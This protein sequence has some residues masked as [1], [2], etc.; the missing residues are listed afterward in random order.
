MRHADG[1]LVLDHGDIV[2]RGTFDELLARRGFFHSL[3][4][5]QFRRDESAEAPPAGG[6]GRGQTLTPAR[7]AP[8]GFRNARQVEGVGRGRLA[9][10]SRQG[11]VT[12]GSAFH[13]AWGRPRQPIESHLRPTKW[14]MARDLTYR[15]SR[16][17]VRLY[18]RAMLQLDVVWKCPPPEG[19]LILAANHPSCTDPFL[20]PLMFH[21]P[22]RLLITQ[23]AFQVPGFGSFLRHLG[24]VP[25]VPR[26]GLPALDAA[27]Q[28]LESGGS[29][30]LFPEGRL[31][32]RRGGFR[33]PRTGAARL[34]M[35]TGVPV[36][37]IGIHLCRAKNYA[38]ASSV[39]GKRTVGYW[40][41]RGPYHVTVGAASRF[42]G[43]LTHEAKVGDVSLAIMQQ[44]VELALESE[45]R[46]KPV[47]RLALVA[48]S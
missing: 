46:A 8:A 17:I 31:S 18:V 29:V 39:T 15:V 16:A 32:P 2:E 27:R 37:P 6:G 7:P 35:L 14:T 12:V 48:P 22:I 10:C 38:I 36:V 26:E 30:A 34:A 9:A 41:V 4:M 20:L 28:L 47:P 3:Y 40:Y 43:D 19:P 23:N 45:L 25:V 11:R 1:V 5:S 13:L 33:A 21:R 44:I 24:H 42:E